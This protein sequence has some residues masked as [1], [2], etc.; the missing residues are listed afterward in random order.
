MYVTVLEE[1][2]LKSGKSFLN[3]GSGSGYLSC[4]AA[5]LLG[6]EGVSHGVEISEFTC[7]FSRERAKAWHTRLINN[8]NATPGGSQASIIAPDGISFV[9][10]NCFDI[11][12]L[13]TVN[14]FKY[15]RI[16]IGA[17]CPD[18]RKE[19]F[20]SMLAD[21]GILV[22]PI[23]ER[24]QMLSI[25]KFCG[26]VY[27]VRPIS[28]VNFAPLIETSIR[29]DEEEILSELAIR[30]G[31]KSLSG[32]I[33]KS[34]QKVQAAPS[35]ASSTALVPS[36]QASAMLP[37]S[38]VSV[39]AGAGVVVQ[40]PATNITSSTVQR[41][42]LPPLGKKCFIIKYTSCLIPY[43]CTVYILLASILSMGTDAHPTLAVPYRVP[44]RSDDHLTC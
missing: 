19:F 33:E 28:N 16:Y 7:N 32:D 35:S 40:V 41:I 6:R 4:L 44:P 22:V 25:R 36:T 29:V 42:R 14:T 12:V 17:G 30:E 31:G 21:N 8:L 18:S 43:Y 1:L 38:M 11:D 3:V 2:D 26:R 9:N 34:I 10:A 23:N 15:D 27:S 13:S 5:F 20:L 37:T 24:N 39:N